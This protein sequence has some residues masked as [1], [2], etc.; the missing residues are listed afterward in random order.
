MSDIEAIAE[1]VLE[2]Q[3]GYL[4]TCFNK[5]QQ[6]EAKLGAIQADLFSLT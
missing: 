3:L 1:A 2:K 6:M 4:E 5:L